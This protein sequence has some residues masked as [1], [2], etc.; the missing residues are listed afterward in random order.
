MPP[1]RKFGTR[2][3]ATIAFLSALGATMSVTANYLGNVLKAIPLLPPGSKQLIARDPRPLD[4]PGSVHDPEDGHG[5][6]HRLPQGP[7]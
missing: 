7:R 1:N 3:W 2:D 5:H 4:N 6:H